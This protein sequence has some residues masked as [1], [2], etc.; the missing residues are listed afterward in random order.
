MQQILIRAYP[1]VM[2]AFL[3]RRS[4]NKPCEEQTRTAGG[5]DLSQEVTTFLRRTPAVVFS[6]LAA[7]SIGLISL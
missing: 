7:Q 6:H 5:H 2:S 4:T 1:P 3:P